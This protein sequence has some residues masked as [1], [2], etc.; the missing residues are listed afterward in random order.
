MTAS[1]QSWLRR[2]RARRGAA[3]AKAGQPYKG[4]R[5]RPMLFR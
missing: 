4:D 2:E 3:V 1:G 5:T